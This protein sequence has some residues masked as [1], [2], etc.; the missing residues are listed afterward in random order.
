MGAGWRQTTGLLGTSSAPAR[1]VTAD[2]NLQEPRPPFLKKEAVMT[3]Q[4]TPDSK[5]SICFLLPLANC[6]IS[7]TPGFFLCRYNDPH[8]IELWGKYDNSWASLVAQLVKNQPAM[9]ETQ[10]LFLDWED[11]LKKG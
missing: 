5:T 3:T 7:L 11:P 8:D 9:Q 10:L 4:H 6:L 1:C 2:T